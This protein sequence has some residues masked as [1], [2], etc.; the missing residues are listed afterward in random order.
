MTEP[1]S[2]FDAKKRAS[3]KPVDIRLHNQ[4][5]VLSLLRTED[6]LSASNLAYSTGLSKTTISKIITEM[7]ARGLV[8]S[9][10]KGE[11]T[12]EGG[13]KPEL[14]SINAQYAASII[15]I[16]DSM[17]RFSCSIVNLR[18]EIMY[19]Q[20]YPL[21]LHAEYEYLVKT[22]A[23]AVVEAEAFLAQKRSTVCGIA[24]GYSG[25]INTE[26]GE[27]LF[28]LQ[29]AQATLCPLRDDLLKY[30]P[31]QNL[32]YIDS[33]CHFSGYAE[34]LM[35][36]QPDVGHLAVISCE[37]IVN[38]CSLPSVKAK[39]GGRGFVGEFG[40][41]IIDPGGSTHCYCGCK[42]CLESLISKQAVIA[43]ARKLCYNFPFSQVAVQ[44]QTDE[45]GVEE[46]CNAA[47]AGDLFAQEI[48]RPV[49]QYLAILIRSLVVLDSV[50]TVIIQGMYARTGTDFLKMIQQQIRSY[51]HASIHKEYSI[52]FSQYSKD[53][54]VAEKKACVRGASYYTANYYLEQ[55][56]S[57]DE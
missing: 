42:G 36:K 49:I 27:I 46:L 18:G 33:T 13:K 29:S 43:R 44:I 39:P 6:M 48:L 32:L 45:I 4:Q 53:G 10:G 5:L 40:H 3:S 38:G 41:L 55:I 51:N 7:I 50:S 30:H 28:P 21:S 23:Q 31:T 12:M 47:S 35:R 24:I 2:L 56:L 11:S 19:E 8:L 34:L 52:E 14:F 16:L 54:P 1:T 57:F 25:V 9:A 20:E 26:T 22:M 37:D 17:D 15:L